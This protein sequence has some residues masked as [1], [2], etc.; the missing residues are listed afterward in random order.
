M[1]AIYFEYPSEYNEFFEKLSD[2]LHEINITDNK[3]YWCRPFQDNTYIK[4]NNK[5]MTKL[6]ISLSPIISEYVI[7]NEKE[8]EKMDLLIE[9]MWQ[10]LLNEDE[11]IEDTPKISKLYINNKLQYD[12]SPKEDKKIKK[13]E[14]W[15][16]VKTWVKGNDLETGLS[17]QSYFNKNVFYKINEIIDKLNKEE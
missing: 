13:L 1:K 14:H 5:K 8:K 17:E 11:I 9:E 7:T 10:E 16:D 12:L 4:D 2:K 6:K 3:K 15:V